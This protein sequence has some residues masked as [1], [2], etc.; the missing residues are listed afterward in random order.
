MAH[1]NTD[2]WGDCAPQDLWPPASY[3]QMGAAWLCLHILEHARFTKDE[4]FLAQYL[5]M[6]REAALFFEDTLQ[7]N[8]VMLVDR[9]AYALKGPVRGDIVV[10]YY[11][12]DYY[13]NRGKSYHTRVKRVVAI[14]GDTIE[15][16]DGTLYVNGEAV[17]EPYLT[18]SRIGSMEIEKRVVPAGC[19]FVLGDNRA[20]SI[21]SRDPEVGPIPYECVVGKVR[22][23]LYPF[24]RLRKV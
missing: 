13:E 23:V 24:G 18:E 12:D 19:C 3:W 9:L 20:V 4:A 21:D 1:H 22:L 7:E 2:V 16:Y 14:A 8:E 11:P 5:P 17:N 10:C 6:I 15:A